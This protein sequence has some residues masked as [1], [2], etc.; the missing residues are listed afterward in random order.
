MDYLSEKLD[1]LSL[2]HVYEQTDY[3]IVDPKITIKCGVLNPI[4]DIFLKKLGKRN[5]SFISAANPRSVVQSDK[6]NAWNNTN[7]EIDLSKSGCSYTY[8][9]GEATSGNWPAEES[10]IVFDM[11]LKDVRS[12]AQKYDQNAILIGRQG[13][14]AQLEWI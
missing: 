5:W 1:E 7:L 14:A 6:L 9:V 12:L 8:A 11:P 2:Q 10:F 4:L 3:R 13:E